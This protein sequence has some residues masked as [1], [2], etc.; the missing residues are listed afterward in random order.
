MSLYLSYSKER[1]KKMSIPVIIVGLTYEE[2]AKHFSTIYNLPFDSSE[3][4]ELLEPMMF[5]KGF[6]VVYPEPE[7]VC[8]DLNVIYGY[9]VL[10]TNS[11]NFNTIEFDPRK[12]KFERAIIDFQ[13]YLGLEPRIFLTVSW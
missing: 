9:I 5:S 13:C 3:L 10:E 11:T 6:D 1:D 4:R 12:I 2:I 8:P 7:E